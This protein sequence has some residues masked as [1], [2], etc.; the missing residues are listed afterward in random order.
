MDMSDILPDTPMVARLY[1]PACEPHAD[2]EKEILDVLW[3]E[4]HLPARG[5]LDDN[6]MPMASAYLSG[7]SEAGGDDNR[8]WCELLH[9]RRPTNG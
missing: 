2:N 1:C 6:N 5:G 9:K 4:S 3:C 8:R 7:G